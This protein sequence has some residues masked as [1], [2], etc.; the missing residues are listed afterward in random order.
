MSLPVVPGFIMI[1]KS[2]AMIMRSDFNYIGGRFFDPL[3]EESSL[4][5]NDYK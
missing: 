5:S 3:P 2:A 1:L 4:R